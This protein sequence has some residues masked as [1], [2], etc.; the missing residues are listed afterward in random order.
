MWQCA[1][2]CTVQDALGKLGNVIK[3]TLDGKK[4][5][6]AKGPRVTKLV[7]ECEGGEGHEV[8]ESDLHKDKLK[9]QREEGC[10]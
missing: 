4:S 3:K 8:R 1:V 5:L 10:I 2:P 9:N 7:Y 6:H